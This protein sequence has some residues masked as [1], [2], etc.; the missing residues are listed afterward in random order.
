MNNLIDEDKTARAITLQGNSPKTKEEEILNPL[1]SGD[2]AAFEQLVER[3]GGRMLATA[4]RFF[5]DEQDAADAVQ[6]AFISAYKGIKA[7][8]ADSL[9]GTWLH[10]IVVNSCLMRRR[11]RDRHPTVAIED[12]LP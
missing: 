3:H 9:L 12:L 1:K 4:R 11:S 8:K 5:H 2:P 6:D 7:F 10:R